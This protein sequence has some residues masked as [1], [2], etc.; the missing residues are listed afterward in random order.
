[1]YKING[2]ETDF[3]VQPVFYLQA[4]SKKIMSEQEVLNLKDC[5]KIIGNYYRDLFD[6]LSKGK[7]G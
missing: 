2:V 6:N 7:I 5:Q 3:S 4:K 1:L